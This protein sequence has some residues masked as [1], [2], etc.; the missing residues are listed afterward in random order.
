MYYA[1]ENKFSLH[2]SLKKH[3]VFC[4]LHRDCDTVIL[5]TPNNLWEKRKTVATTGSAWRGRNVTHRF[6]LWRSALLDL[7]LEHFDPLGL[8]YPPEGMLQWSQGVAT[9]ANPLTD[10]MEQHVKVTGHKQ[11]FMLFT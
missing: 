10:W 5:S 9:D 1:K 2:A 7:L 11:D 8:D 4:K 3:P 6:P